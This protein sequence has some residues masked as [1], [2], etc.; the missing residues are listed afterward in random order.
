MLMTDELASATAI[1]RFGKP[2]DEVLTEEPFGGVLGSSS[3]FHKIV[4]LS[5]RILH[6]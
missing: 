4:L 6:S 2:I 5:R 1:W 3:T